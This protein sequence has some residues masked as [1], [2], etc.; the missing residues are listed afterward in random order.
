[1]LHNPHILVAYY[2]S[3]A[4]YSE[5]VETIHRRIKGVLQDVPIYTV[6]EA[7]ELSLDMVHWRDVTEGQWAIT[8]DHYVAECL[9]RKLYTN[10]EYPNSFVRT[11]CGY[12]WD[13][14][15][16]PFLFEER[17]ANRS[18]YMSTA[19]TLREKRAR[20]RVGKHI[21]RAAATM[22]LSDK[23]LDYEILANIYA[24]RNG[25]RLAAKKY[26]RQILNSKAGRELI[27][28]EIEKAIV[29]N[30]MTVHKWLEIG[31]QIFDKAQEKDNLGEMRK[32]WVHF[33]ELLNIHD[34]REISP[35]NGNVLDAIETD[36]KELTNG[37]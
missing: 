28:Q 34:T 11:T 15:K 8:D 29:G 10:G 36:V 18:W 5:P 7:E 19:E 27:R 6:E 32:M 23:P 4:L 22:W 1:M 17:K 25:N 13:N 35:V 24:K 31:V 9:S 16:R 14:T 33:G 37:K 12:F 21:C 3:I 2:I 26:V 30:G 20:R